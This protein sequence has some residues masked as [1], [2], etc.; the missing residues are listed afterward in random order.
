MSS[1]SHSEDHTMK[2]LSE[3][4]LTLLERLAEMFPNNDYQ[5]RLDRYIDSKNPQHVGEVE[6]LIK[7]FDLNQQRGYL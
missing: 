4:M 5:A 2:T 3:M 6:D 1:Y 7:R